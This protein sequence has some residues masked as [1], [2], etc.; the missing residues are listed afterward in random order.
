VQSGLFAVS[1]V[2]VAGMGV[3]AVGVDEAVVVEGWCHQGYPQA[4]T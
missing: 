2:V 3:G 4:R 1:S